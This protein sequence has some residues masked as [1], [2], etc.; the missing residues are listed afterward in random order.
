[1]NDIDVQSLLG[2]QRMING[3]VGSAYKA[4]INQTLT[5]AYAL[6]DSMTYMNSCMR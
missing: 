2:E 6:A 4:R 1:M 3:S 5:T